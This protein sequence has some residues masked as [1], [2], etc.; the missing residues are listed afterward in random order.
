M[1]ISNIYKL[2][3]KVY[4]TKMKPSEIRMFG[5]CKSNEGTISVLSLDISENDITDGGFTGGFVRF[6]P[7]SVSVINVGNSEY[8]VVLVNG[9]DSE[10]DNFDEKISLGR[11]DADLIEETDPEST[12]R[13]ILL[14]ILK[15]VRRHHRGNLQL[16]QSG[17]YI[18][19]PDNFW[20]IKLQ[21]RDRS[22]RITLRG[23]PYK[24]DSIK[25]LKIKK[26]LNGY[27]TFKISSMD[28]VKEAVKT[29]LIAAK[30]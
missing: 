29:I 15:G 19:T 26:D 24:F 30:K 25:N 3:D 9:T 17:K 4:T 28:H 13:S 14:E 5:D 20:T 27:S 18:E 23:N 7:D 12:L 6:Q 8:T 11:G 2:D 16:S 10:E 22:F 1:T 21:P